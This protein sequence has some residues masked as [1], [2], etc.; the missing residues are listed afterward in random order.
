MPDETQY[1]STDPWEGVLEDAADQAGLPTQLLGA[2]SEQEGVHPRHNNP[3]GLST[4][5]GVQSFDS[6]DAVNRIYRQ[7]RLMNDPNGPYREYVRTGN[8]NALARVYSPV[9]AR[10]DPYHTNVTEASGITSALKKRYVS[11]DP[12]GAEIVKAEPAEPSAAPTPTAP[13]HSAQWNQEQAAMQ[14]RATQVGMPD[15]PNARDRLI[16]AISRSE[17][18]GFHVPHQ[19]GQ[20][21]EPTG[22]YGM[23]M[24]VQNLVRSLREREKTDPSVAKERAYWENELK[25]GMY[26]PEAGGPELPGLDPTTG[27]WTPGAGLRTPETEAVTGTA[28]R[29]GFGAEQPV[30]G[31]LTQTPVADLLEMRRIAEARAAAAAETRKPAEPT[32][33]DLEQA[34]AVRAGA[35]MRPEPE[36]PPPDPYDVASMAAAEREL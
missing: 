25:S 21:K 13:D 35:E 30:V 24:D 20:P 26:S 23:T 6:G 18:A 8:I 32:Q 31:Q 10:N 29:A 7:A 19:I 16:D 17:Q 15:I 36:L 9:G 22:D 12:N 14:A 2:I 11:T 27:V 33:A 4:D 3:L 28:A 1:V 34:M 5:A